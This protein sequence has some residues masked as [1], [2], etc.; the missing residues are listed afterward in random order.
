MRLFSAEHATRP[1]TTRTLCGRV[2]P[3]ENYTYGVETAGVITRVDDLVA[4]VTCKTCFR[5]AAR[6]FD[7]ADIRSAVEETGSSLTEAWVN[8]LIGPPPHHEE[9]EP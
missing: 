9:R 2:L 7:E 3:T 6:D 4:Y 8:L 1:G 5:I